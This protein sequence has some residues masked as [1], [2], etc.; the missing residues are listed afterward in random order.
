MLRAM[1]CSHIFHQHCIF[2]WLHRNTVCPLCRYQLPTT[3]E[4]EDTEVEKDE[5]EMDNSNSRLNQIRRRLQI[6]YN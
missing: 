5:E 2:Q 3:F 6:L 4:D 1:P